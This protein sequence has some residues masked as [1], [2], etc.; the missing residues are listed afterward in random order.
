MA[1]FASRGEVATPP[2]TYL[3]SLCL[4]RREV[5]P[6]T[7]TPLTYTL[8]VAKHETGTVTK[9][10]TGAVSTHETGPVTKQTTGA[11]FKHETGTVTKQTIGAVSRHETGTVTKQTTGAVSRHETGTVTKQTTGALQFMAAFAL[12]GG[13]ATP[14][15][16]YLTPLCPGRREVRP[17]TSTPLTYTITVS[18]HETG[19]VTEQTTG[20]MS[21]HE[22]GTV[23]KQ[24]TGARGGFA[25][26]RV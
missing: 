26:L 17:R 18:K 9:Q 3:T 14:P 8:T 11:V 15:R 23:T 2:R 7:S 13:V 4:G 22:A 16:I 6:R 1:A 12:R 24:T 25:S 20:A 5:R 21:T 19:T 10:T